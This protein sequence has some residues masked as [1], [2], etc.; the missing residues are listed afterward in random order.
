MRGT[1]M[2]ALASPAVHLESSPTD[3]TD[4]EWEM[5]RPYVEVQTRTGPKQWVNL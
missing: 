5:L 2:V 4:E 1:G 3:L